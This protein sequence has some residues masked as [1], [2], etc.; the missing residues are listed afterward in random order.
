MATTARSIGSVTLTIASVAIP[1]KL[2]TAQSKREIAFNRLDRKTGSRVKQQL[3]SAADGR[4]LEPAD[5]ISGY[6]YTPDHFVTFEPAEL[7]A[8]EAKADPD[9]LRITSV[10]SLETFDAMHVVKSNILAPDKGAERAYHLLASLLVHRAEVAVGQWGGRTRDDV[11]VVSPRPM[12]DGK[13]GLVVHECLYPDE[14]RSATLAEVAPAGVTLPP[15]ELELGARLLDQFERESFAA[16]LAGLVD[17]GAARV[18]AA[19]EEKAA[20]HQIVVPPPKDGAAPVDLLAQLEASVPARG[21]KKARATP[22]ASRLQA[23]RRARDTG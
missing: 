5:L 11:V 1:A 21:P 18:K 4:V 9:R 6:E 19:V 20:G 14:V 16:A 7:K 8:L 15:R 17:G 13:I 10:V 3:V 23:R 12:H 2:Y 22:P